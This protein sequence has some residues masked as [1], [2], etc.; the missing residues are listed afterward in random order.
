MLPEY[1][2]RIDF[3]FNDTIHYEKTITKNFF[4]NIIATIVS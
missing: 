3:V 4:E 1:I 2:W